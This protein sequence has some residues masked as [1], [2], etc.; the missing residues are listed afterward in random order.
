MCS[1][2]DVTKWAVV[3]VGFS[4]ILLLSVIICCSLV[5]GCRCLKTVIDVAAAVTDCSGDAASSRSSSR[6]GRP[7]LLLSPVVTNMS[8]MSLMLLLVLVV[9]QV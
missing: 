7:S 3:D 8:L 9:Q 6:G 1:V 4:H 2:L 5:T